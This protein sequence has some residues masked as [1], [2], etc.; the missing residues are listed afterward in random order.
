MALES[1]RLSSLH[2]PYWSEGTANAAG[3][4]LKQAKHATFA[5]TLAGVHTW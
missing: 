3:V 1:S 2:S 5:T 4:K